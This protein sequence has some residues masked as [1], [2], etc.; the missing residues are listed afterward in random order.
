MGVDYDP[1]YVVHIQ[2]IH[3]ELYLPM[4]RAFSQKNRR[5]STTNPIRRPKLTQAM[6]LQYFDRVE[7]REMLYI[8]NWDM[9]EQNYASLP[10]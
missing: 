5:N 10:A 2:N 8:L 7:P 3:K 9:R 4:M 6:I 1:K